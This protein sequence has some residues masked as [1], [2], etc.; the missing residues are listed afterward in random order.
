[1]VVFS[2]R[3]IPGNERA[4]HESVC[5]L[6]RLGAIVH[7][8]HTD[9]DVHVSGHASRAEQERMLS[10]IRP[11]AFV[12]VHGSL[13][14]LNK[15][16]KLAEMAGCEEIRII[17]NGACLRLSGGKLYPSDGVRAG[18]IPIDLGGRPLES[19]AL[20]ERIELGRQGVTSVSLV[21][22]DNGSLLV[23]PMVSLWGIP[24]VEDRASVIR[25]INLELSRY[26]PQLI[27]RH[28]NV[29]E[30]VRRAV[31]RMVGDETG[32]RPVV[33]VHVHHVDD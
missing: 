32:C 24:G 17:E 2:S 8:R 33:D 14:H 16:A 15:H 19:S 4:V 27:R 22:G 6:M 30:E 10:L 7:T 11:K 26:V 20:E 18:R 9:P 31:R 12:P 23:P 29:E 25:A 13:H 28:R 5:D 1:M 3:V 21:V